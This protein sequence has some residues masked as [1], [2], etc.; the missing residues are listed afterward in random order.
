MTSTFGL[1]YL[2]WR[3]ENRIRAFDLVAQK[4]FFAEA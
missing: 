2:D 1:S 3:V 4:N